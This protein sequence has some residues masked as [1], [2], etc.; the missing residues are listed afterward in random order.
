M[1]GIL[2][3]T[4]GDRTVGRGRGLRTGVRATW[5]SSRLSCTVHVDALCMD[6]DAKTP[7]AV[8]AV[9]GAK[10]MRPPS[11]QHDCNHYVVAAAAVA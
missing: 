10:Q 6:L 2:R 8:A 5:P 4:R 3:E 9:C 1:H 7:A 11:K